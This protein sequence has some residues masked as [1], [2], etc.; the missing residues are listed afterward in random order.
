MDTELDYYQALEVDRN[1]DGDTIKKS[2]RRLAMKYHPDRNPNNKE[3]E[4]KFKYC[5]EAYEVLK[6]EQKRAAYDRYGHNAFKQNSGM[7]GGG[8]P[9][10]FDFGFG[11]G[12]FSDIF[13][14]IFS[15]FMGGNNRAR[16]HSS[17]K[18]GD[19]LQYHLEINLEESFSGIEKEIKFNRKSSCEKCSGMGTKDGSKP[20]PCPS[21]HGSGRQRIQRGFFLV[22]EECTNCHGEG[23]II[24][25]ACSNCR[26][27]GYVSNQ[28]TLK[29]KIPA[30][31]E[32]NSRV[33]LSGKGNSGLRGGPNGDLYVFV[34]VK[35]HKL[36]YREA[37]HLL[38][39]VPISMVTASIGGTVE[40]PAIDGE[41][42]EVKIAAGTDFGTQI[43]IKNKGMT[44]LNSN[45]RGD[46]IVQFKVETPK[47]LTA[48][49]KEILSEFQEISD[50]HNSHP[51]TKSFLD[52]VKDLFAKVS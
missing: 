4:E 27:K 2:Y 25:D 24:K 48:R 31:I 30:G 52:K 35:K 41:K 3:A 33:R 7:G 32:D 38:A 39:E 16:P 8:N 9:F 22:E 49:Q 11:T 26:G 47:K 34:S 15:D 14:D 46:L 43:R 23:H 1:A 12:G 5:C 18:R 29:V 10:G 28:E 40:L 6:D 20:S 13:T 37:S 42:L 36:Y 19:D 17:A 21:C 45:S 50:E 51:D 44:K